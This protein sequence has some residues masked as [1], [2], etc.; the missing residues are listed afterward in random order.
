MPVWKKD[1]FSVIAVT[2]YLVVYCVLLRFDLTLDFAVWM[3]VFSPVAL[4][5][6]VL[7][8]LKHGAYTG[9]ELGEEEFGYQDKKK[10]DLGV[11]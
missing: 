6:M 8:V 9:P 7:R 5:W 4:V 2:A 3:F 1:T 11:W 10:D